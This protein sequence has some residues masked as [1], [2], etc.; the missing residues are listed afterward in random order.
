MKISKK[1][2]FTSA[3]L[4][5]YLKTVK[6]FSKLEEEILAIITYKY[7]YQKLNDK[8]VLIG[9]PYKENKEREINNRPLLEAQD[10][11]QFKKKIR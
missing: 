7:A 11:G 3:E 4:I 6:K 10:I 2:L 1:L 8:D 9:F 5:N